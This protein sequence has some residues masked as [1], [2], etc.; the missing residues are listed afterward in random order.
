MNPTDLKRKYNKALRN[1]AAAL[2]LAL[3]A[4][5]YLAD[6][7]IYR[8]PLLLAFGA[9]AAALSFVFWRRLP[10]RPEG[11]PPDMEARAEALYDRAHKG[12]PS[13]GCSSRS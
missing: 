4:A 2:L 7:F 12:A 10:P 11:V 3:F 9:V 6:M 8:E 13:A 5:V 1:A